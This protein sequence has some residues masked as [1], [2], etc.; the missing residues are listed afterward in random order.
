MFL[1]I[2]ILFLFTLQAGAVTRISTASGNWF[3]N[4]TWSPAGVPTCGDSIIIVAGHTVSVDGS[5][6]LSGCGSRLILVV[7]GALSFGSGN[8]MTLA[9]SSRLYVFA[10]GT[11]VPSGGGNSNNIV[12]CGTTYWKAGDGKFTGPACIPATLPGCNSV[13]P[14]RLSQFAATVCGQMVCIGWQTTSEHDCEKFELERSVDGY[15]FKTIKSVASQAKNGKSYSK[16]NYEV[17]DVFSADITYYR[18]KQ[19][20]FDHGATYS[21]IVAVHRQGVLMSG[22][23]IYPNPSS[24]SFSLK[25]EGKNG[26]ALLCY[27]VVDPF[28]KVA[29]SGAGNVG[30]EPDIITITPEVN[31]VP[32]TYVVNVRAGD[33]VYRSKLI[34]Q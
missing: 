25:I 26:N 3:T 9:C 29:L 5:P 22:F 23:S 10:T 17:H 31:L 24:G 14:V 2:L 30:S 4:G 33:H 6:S 16:L 21:D 34:I 28:G 13:L 8:K 20:D 1:R 15:Q 18:L 32:G 27:T 12:I 11:I 19:I 7:R